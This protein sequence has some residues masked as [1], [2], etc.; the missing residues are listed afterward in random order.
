MKYMHVMYEIKVKVKWSCYRPGVAQRVG[1]G[2]ALLFHDRGTRRGWVVSSM[3]RPHFTPRKDPVPILQE[4]GWAPGPVWTGG[5][6]RPHQDSILTAQP[7]VSRYTNWATQPMLCMKYCMKITT[8]NMM[9]MQDFEVLPNKFY[10]YRIC[11]SV[12][13]NW[14]RKTEIYAAGKKALRILLGTAC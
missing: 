8:T 2:I 11:T 3:P 1:R 14:M 13:L 5:K 7:V 9:T 6:S 10:I 4:A 12:I